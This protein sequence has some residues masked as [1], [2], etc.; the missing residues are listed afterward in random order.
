MGELNNLFM[1]SRQIC[2]IKVVELK[3]FT[4]KPAEKALHPRSCFA[5]FNDIVRTVAVVA[6]Y[7]DRS[8]KSKSMDSIKIVLSTHLNFHPSNILSRLDESDPVRLTNEAMSSN[9]GSKGD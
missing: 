9:I 1:G 8:H 5:I 3:A 2:V 6:S 7:F 4:A